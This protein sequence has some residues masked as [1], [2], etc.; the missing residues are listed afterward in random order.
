MIYKITFAIWQSL[1]CIVFSL[2][3]KADPRPRVVL[4]DWPG[5]LNRRQYFTLATVDLNTEQI[6]VYV[7]K[8]LVPLANSPQRRFFTE[9]ASGAAAQHTSYIRNLRNQMSDIE[10]ANLA[11]DKSRLWEALKRAGPHTTPVVSFR[12]FKKFIV[13]DGAHRLAALSELGHTKFTVGVS[14]WSFIKSEQQ[15]S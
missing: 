15:S 7:G 10:I 13:E 2:I 4:G 11:R 6:F 5:S 1:F 9:L 12:T 8:E 14:I 3:G